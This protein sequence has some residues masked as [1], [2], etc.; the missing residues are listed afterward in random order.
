MLWKEEVE[1]AGV[2]TVL[3]GFDPG[4]FFQAL[5]QFLCSRSSGQSLTH[6]WNRCSIAVLF[7]MSEFI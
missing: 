6:Q 5:W 4:N 3:P 2:Q 7:L 1:V